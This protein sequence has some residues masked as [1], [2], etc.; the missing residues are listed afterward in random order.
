MPHY[1]AHI[2]QGLI[3]KRVWG[4]ALPK[5]PYGKKNMIVPNDNVNDNDNMSQNRDAFFT[6]QFDILKLRLEPF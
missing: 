1:G 4:G 2:L 3:D 5:N 6:S